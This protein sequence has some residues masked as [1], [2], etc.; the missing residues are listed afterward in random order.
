VRQIRLVETYLLRVA[1]VAPPVAAKAASIQTRFTNGISFTNT[2]GD[3]R[4]N[5]LIHFTSQTF[6]LV[7]RPLL[8]DLIEVGTAG[9]P[10]RVLFHKRDRGCMGLTGKE[11]G[12]VASD[13][14]IS[15]TEIEVLT[16]DSLAEGLGVI[17]PGSEE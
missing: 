16:S 12:P 14:V 10:V 2:T 7:R 11:V 4:C 5:S 13:I 3:S 17:A 1:E 6:R 8:Q 15:A 9:G